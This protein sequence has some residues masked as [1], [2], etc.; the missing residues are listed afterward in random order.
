[1]PVE[2][3]SEAELD[4]LERSEIPDETKKLD[5]LVPGLKD[6]MRG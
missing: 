2:A 4:D 1:M 5:V 6:P 3:L